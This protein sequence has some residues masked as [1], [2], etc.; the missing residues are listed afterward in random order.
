MRLST[1]RLVLIASLVFS[2]MLSGFPAARPAA[3]DG[4]VGPTVSVT[5]DESSAVYSSPYCGFNSVWGLAT[6]FQYRATDPSEALTLHVAVVANDLPGYDALLSRNITAVAVTFKGLESQQ[7]NYTPDGLANVAVLQ[8]SVAGLG[9]LVELGVSG[10]CI[11]GVS[12]QDKYQYTDPVTHAV[13]TVTVDRGASVQFYVYALKRYGVGASVLD[14]QSVTATG[15]D[16]FFTGSDPALRTKDGLGIQAEFVQPSHLKVTPESATTYFVDAI[17]ASLADFIV[18]ADLGDFGSSPY[19]TGQLRLKASNGATS[20]TPVRLAYAHIAS[21]RG[22]V[23][24]QGALG[25]GWVGAQPGDLLNPGDFVRLGSV[26]YDQFDRPIYPEISIRFADLSVAQV[27]EFG[28]RS[29]AMVF[30]VDPGS[31]SLAKDETWEN[32]KVILSKG[33]AKGVSTFVPGGPVVQWV[34]KQ[35]VEQVLKRASSASDRSFFQSRAPGIETDTAPLSVELVGG[36]DKTVQITNSG[37]PLVLEGGG[38]STTILWNT[39]VTQDLGSAAVTPPVSLPRSTAQPLEISAAYAGSAGPLLPPL[40]TRSP[41]I[42]LLYPGGPTAQADLASLNVR[43]NGYLVTGQFHSTPVS[44]TWQ[45]GENGVLRSGTNRLTAGLGTLGGDRASLVQELV[46]AGAPDSPRD[47]AVRAG[48]TTTALLW[49]RSLDPEVTGYR[50]SRAGSAA[51]PWATLGNSSLAE[52]FLWDT[53]PPAGPVWYRVEA[54]QGNGTASAPSQPISAVLASTRGLVA[55]PSPTV[56]ATAGDR[57]VT[58]AYSQAPAGTVGL[59]LE[60]ATAAPGPWSVL[61]GPGEYLGPS[62]FVDRSVTNGTSY[63]YRLTPLGYDRTPGAPAVTGPIQPTDVAPPAPQG[64]TGYL[65]RGMARLDWDPTAAPDLAGYRVYRA[66]PGGIFQLQT[67]IPTTQ[68]AFSQAIERGTL[69]FYKVT[70]VDSAGQESAA[71]TERLISARA[72]DELQI[73]LLGNSQGGTVELDS[74]DVQFPYGQVVT[75][76]AVPAEGFSFFGWTGDIVSEQNPVSFPM[77]ADTRLTPRFGPTL[78]PG[79]LPARTIAGNDAFGSIDG[80]GGSLVSPNA[81]AAA[82]DGSLVIADSNKIRRLLVTGVLTTVAG[83]DAAGYADGAGSAARFNSPA[84]LAVDSAGIVYV[85]DTQNHRI[86]RVAQDGTVTTIAGSGNPAFRNGAGVGASFNFPTGIAIGGDGALYVADRFNFN[87]RRVTLDGQVTTFAGTSEPGFLDGDRATAK[88][89]EPQGIAF[90]GASFFVADTENQRI[91]KIGADGLVSTAAGTGKT[92][93]ADGPAGAATFNAPRAVVLQAGAM[94]VADRGS[95]RIR[96]IWPDGTVSTLAGGPYGFFESPMAAFA[97]PSGLALLGPND[98]VVADTGNRRLRA[99]A[100]RAAGT[101]LP[102]SPL[103]YRW[104]TRTLTL[105]APSGASLVP[106]ATRAA[107]V[108]AAV[109]IVALPGAPPSGLRI[110]GGAFSVEVAGPVDAAVQ[111]SAAEIPRGAVPNLDRWD[112]GSLVWVPVSVRYDAMTNT[113]YT[114]ISSDGVFATFLP[115]FSLYVP[116]AVRGRID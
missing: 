85:A 28:A 40:T 17:G 72:V 77:T 3:A 93:A 80:A 39:R 110:S 114:S 21:V 90:D 82:P 58:L 16:V 68:P 105:T 79:A 83:G 23:Q 107:G 57:T 108:A 66:A 112:P 26:L 64:V 48:R 70:A 104:S 53:A 89:L 5:A 67:E 87:I 55:P 50:V 37:T 102:G 9:G 99:I 103:V 76:R 29:T 52:P 2:S 61:P 65:D 1:V 36:A 34:A 8:G 71:S 88:F 56:T 97:V 30:S 51:G 22:D 6:A 31:L 24:R 63:W 11:C 106:A 109:R 27:G 14:D 78:I 94:F 38:A 81:V 35:G 20:L 69:Y 47:L 111:F 60:R 25:G 7:F 44:A 4:C 32:V 33:V 15:G 49:S 98:L 101:V 41:R 54:L 86:R 10:D 92:G 13:S 113:L 42:D 18:Y 96:A 43:L 95:N 19:E 62:P 12:F 59:R 91:R 75:A 84:G 73:L 115:P 46:A 45:L 100:L 116:M 74:T